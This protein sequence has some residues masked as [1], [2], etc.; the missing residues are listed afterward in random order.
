MAEEY[1]VEWGGSEEE[2]EG[3]EE[4]ASEEGEETNEEEER[5]A[6]AASQDGGGGEGQCPPHHECNV[7]LT[8]FGGSPSVWLRAAMMPNTMRGFSPCVLEQTTTIKVGFMKKA[9][10]ATVRRVSKELY[11]HVAHHE[12]WLAAAISSLHRSQHPLRGNTFLQELRARA[13][14]QQV[15]N[16]FQDDQDPMGSLEAGG[17]ALAGPETPQKRARTKTTHRM[18]AL[19]EEAESPIDVRVVGVVADI[20]VFAPHERPTM[21]QAFFRVLCTSSSGKGGP[22][23]LYVWEDHL[24]LLVSILFT[25]VSRQAG[26]LADLPAD[27]GAPAADDHPAA[28]DD[29]DSS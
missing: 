23:M 11:I 14:A 13:F 21:E 7:M 18:V 4:E 10:T 24:D 19:A 27:S 22:K 17:P 1:E 20:N 3:E 25:L 5:A 16:Q 29:N 28:A 15:A 9:S 6:L 12:P 26:R 8:K 2:S